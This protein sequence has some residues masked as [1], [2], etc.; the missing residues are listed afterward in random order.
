MFAAMPG[1]SVDDG[2]LNLG[3]HA[4]VINT[5][6]TEP[7]PILQH[8]PFEGLRDVCDSPLFLADPD[9]SCCRVELPGPRHDL[10]SP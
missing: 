7:S 9:S 1:F 3:L 6:P 2:H 5:L 8:P 4:C 10:A